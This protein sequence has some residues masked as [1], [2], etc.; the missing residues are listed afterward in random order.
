MEWIEKA[1]RRLPGLCFAESWWIHGNILIDD[2]GLAKIGLENEI[3]PMLNVPVLTVSPEILNDLLFRVFDPYCYEEIIWSG[4]GSKIVKNSLSLERGIEVSAK[5]H[6]YKN[7]NAEVDE[8]IV[9][10]ERTVAVIDDVVSSGV[11]ALEVFK[12]GELGKVRLAALSVWIMQPPRDKSLRCYNGGVFAGALVHGPNGKIPVNS[13]YA[14]VKRP[15]VLKDYSERFAKKYEE[16]TWF[17][18]WLDK[19]VFP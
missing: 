6:G 15:E 4:E 5:R 19:E 1:K 8:F 10:P 11:T 9:S 12:K 16:F 18:R 14:L 7:P 2:I 3:P 17:F 13:L